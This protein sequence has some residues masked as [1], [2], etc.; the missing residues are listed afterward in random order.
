MRELGEIASHHFDVVIVRED[1]NLRGRKPGE[2]S[3][4]V[5]EGVRAGMASGARC[6]QL[7][8]VRDEIAAVR[9][10]LSRAN[11][12]DLVVIC[13]DKH[14]AV[15]AELENWSQQAQAGAGASASAP[16]ADPDYVP[17]EPAA[18]V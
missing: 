6:K 12:G 9:H 14:P 8:E 4:L 2:V 10:A 3:G 7:E 11:A 1:D 15:M 17:S 13:V 16:A 18:T 5:I